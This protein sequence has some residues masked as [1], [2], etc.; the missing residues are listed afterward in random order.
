MVIFALV[1]MVWTTIWYITP[2]VFC[3]INNPFSALFWTAP[4]ILILTPILSK[5]F[6][7]CRID[8][9]TMPYGILSRIWWW[10]LATS[11]LM[12]AFRTWWKMWPIAIIV[13]SSVV[14]SIILSM[15]IWKEKINLWT[16]IW[17]GIS[18][19]WLIVT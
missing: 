15:L 17:C 4:L 2:K 16:A 6:F 1:G 19:I 12:L 18:F 14:F 11:W 7:W 8:F 9:K 5:V 13:E 3:S 10:L